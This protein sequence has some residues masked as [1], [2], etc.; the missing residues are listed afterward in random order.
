M[1]VNGAVIAPCGTNWP[2]MVTLYTPAAASDE[3]MNWPLNSCLELMLHDAA[4]P[5]LK[6]VGGS[7]ATASTQFA[8]AAA[9]PVPVNVTVVPAAPLVGVSVN[10]PAWVTVVDGLLG[11]CE[12]RNVKIAAARS[13]IMTS[14]KAPLRETRGCPRSCLGCMIPLFSRL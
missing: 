11:G 13:R 6:S 9:Y 4:A 12:L 1:T 10:V 2:A 7:V 5:P 3:T 14:A 8:A